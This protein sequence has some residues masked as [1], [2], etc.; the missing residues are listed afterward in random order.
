MKLGAAYVLFNDIEYLNLSLD[1]VSKACDTVLF[2]VGRYPW[3]NIENATSNKHIV[4]H[5]AKLCE[6]NSKYQMIVGEWSTEHEQRNDGLETLKK[7]GISHALIVDTDEIYHL[8]HLYHLRQLIL[9]NSNIY[10]FHS[11]WNTYWKNFYRVEPR[12]SFVPLIAVK[13]ENFKFVN[14]RAGICL[15]DKGEEIDYCGFSIPPHLVMLYHLSY[16]RTDEFMKNKIQFFSHAD[17]ILENWYNE[18]WLKWKEGDT[19]FH[20]VVPN[21]YHSAVKENIFEFPDI[22]RD[23][24]IARKSN[25]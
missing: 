9:T 1:A 20:P 18:V 17:E 24:L 6:S 23:F 7:Q 2:I 21:Q 5:I 3:N 16:V 19:N 10:A 14:R 11:S 13:C 12:E 22:L 15:N 8:R 25:V 4:D